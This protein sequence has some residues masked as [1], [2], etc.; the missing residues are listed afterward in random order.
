MIRRLKRQLLRPSRPEGDRAGRSANGVVLFEARKGP[1][2]WIA[3]VPLIDL[4]SFVEDLET[5]HAAHITI[6]ADTSIVQ[7][8]EETIVVHVGPLSATGTLEE[9]RKVLD[10]ELGDVY[11]KGDGPEI[12]TPPPW[13][14]GRTD[15]PILDS[16]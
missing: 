1:D 13:E 11:A 7:A 9:W 14:G 16:E 8:G 15:F 4:L 3:G 2:H 10:R 6:G 12:R 5:G